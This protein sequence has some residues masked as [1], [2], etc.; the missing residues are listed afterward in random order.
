MTKM[1]RRG[2]LASSAGLV[3]GLS[4]P[5]A[6][7][8]QSG[9]A[10]ALSSGAGG[11]ASFAP[12][13]FVRVAPDDTVTVMIKHIEF[14][15]G[16]YT[17]LSTLV[18]EEM[19]A[20]WSQMRAEAAPANNALYKNLAFG[21]QGTGGSTA[22]ANSYMQMRKAGA[23]AR[24]MLVAAAAADWG[25]D[26]AE[27]TVSKGVV[28]HG[29]KTASFGALANA[30][31]Q[32]TPPEDPP[33]KT[34]DQFVLIGTDLP[35]LDTAAKTNGTATF[36]MD[37][38][39]DGMQTV[40]VAH[41]PKFG[42]TVASF[43]AAEALKVPG[44]S[45]V[46]QIPQ[47]VAVYAAST[48][49][50]IKGRNGLRIDW[51][52]SAAETRSSDE[53]YAAFS[54]IAAEGGKD[55]ELIG[56]GAAGID[57]AAQIIE[58]EFRFPYLAHAPMEP[59]DGVIE[60]REDGAEVWMGSQFPALDLPAVAGVL[61]LD[62]SAVAV[63]VM[64]AGGSFGR[65]AQDTAHFAAELA[66]V[67]KA[68]GPGA[69]KL[70]W[71]REDDLAGGYYRPLTV[72]RMRAGLAE[73]GTLLGWEDVIANQSIMAGGPMAQ[74]M[75]DGM[76]PTAYEGATK[77]PY[78][79]RHARIGWAQVD[80]PVSVLWWRSVGHSHTGYATEVFLDMVLEAQGKDPVQGRL[81]LMKPEAGRDRAVLEKVAQMA[82][83]DGTKVRD[84]K[85]Y[86]VALHESFETY[87]AQIAEVEDRGGMPH[88]TR[89]WCAVDCGVAV[90]P[91]VIRAQMEGGIGFGIGSVLF[92]EITLAPG[93]TVMQSN[94]DTYR[95]LRIH[96]MPEVMVEIIASDADPTGVGEPGLPP[97]GPAIANAW[98][99][100]S[101]TNVTTLPFAKA[102]V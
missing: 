78:D 24:A 80:S 16:P 83:W 92:D 81:E 29:D 94:F 33:V 43:D 70:V 8:A 9:A 46:Q 53:I 58:A 77:M 89:V 99:A 82:G 47:G 30:A 66:E 41:P 62:A 27:I 51:D 39:R 54:E 102:G 32:M 72:H 95:M 15:Q 55:A 19:D 6:A 76:D 96:E 2:F 74:M 23:A 35:K 91:N 7:R 11:E 61:G 79:M 18:A 101:G 21:L 52:D 68:A 36:T 71:T 5:I 64:L 65:R 12:N 28:S 45:A 22:M 85:G 42:G 1:N 60:L 63:N 97:I 87:V 38:Y 40:T 100:L 57:G 93:G 37:L 67:A 31:A 48:Y 44:V 20:D 50:A 90:N 4:L 98:R 73:D 49:A 75:Q 88:V 3:I 17:G 10:A 13:A 25:V 26:A 14:G 86:G 59:L 34:A 56:N 69:Y 84:G